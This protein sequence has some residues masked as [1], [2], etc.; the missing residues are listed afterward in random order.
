MEE[1]INT[2]TTLHNLLDYD[3]RKF[4]V[5]ETILEACLTNWINKAGTIKLKTILQQ[6]RAVVQIHSK[7]MQAFVEDEQIQLVSTTSMVMTAYVAEANEKLAHCSD[8]PIMDACIVASVQAINHFKISMYGTA[9]AFANTLGMEKQAA[10][11]HEAT[12][13]EKKIDDRLSQLAAFEVNH[14]A[15][16]PLALPG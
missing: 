5:A 8:A 9:A 15:S 2:I 16:S 13:H 12:I 6:Y 10:L 4:I 7:K 1:N 3:A 14:S 11:F